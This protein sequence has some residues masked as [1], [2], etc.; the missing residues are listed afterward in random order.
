MNEYVRITKISAEEKPYAPTPDMSDYKA[1]EQN[2][3]VSLP[4]KYT[5]TGYLRNDVEVGE[6]LVV[7]RDTR[8]GV[9][10]Q[11]IFSTSPVQDIEL[12]PG[13]MLFHTENSVYRLEWI[14]ELS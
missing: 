10:M 6:R 3:G 4:V 12:F 13:G 8:N 14:D 5:L 11:G 7:A 9:K 1:G 2:S